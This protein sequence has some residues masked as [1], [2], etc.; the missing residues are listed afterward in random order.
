MAP[1][2]SEEG[3]G[4]HQKEEEMTMEEV[5]LQVYRSVSG[6]FGGLLLRNGVEDG[7]VE[8]CATQ[9]EVELQ[10]LEA[11]INPDRVEVLDQRPTVARK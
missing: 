8:G 5:V 4:K 7:R 2:R 11:G 9:E 3:H 10:A 1:T 6:Q